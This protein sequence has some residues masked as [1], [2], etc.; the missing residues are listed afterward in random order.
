[1]FGGYERFAY[2][3]V[4]SQ[5]SRWPR[6]A[7]RTIENMARGAFF[8]PQDGRRQLARLL[9]VAQAPPGERLVALSSIIQKADLPQVFLPDFLLSLI[10]GEEPSRCAA[11]GG[12]SGGAEL[13][14]FTVNYRLPGDYLKK[15]DV[16]SSAHGLEVRV[17]MLSNRI[18]AFAQH[19]PNRLKYSLLKNKLL[20]R[21]LAEKYLPAEVVNK[22][23]QG[24]GIPLDTWLGKKGREDVAAFLS[25]RSSRILEFIRQD[26]V[27]S[28]ANQF[29]GGEWDRSHVSRY[30]VYQRAYA[31]WSLETWLRQWK[32]SL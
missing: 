5:I 25:S 4:A 22:R 23:K 32:P 27:H 19:L 28:V 15:I 30:S 21:R 24:F 26:F 2:A 16:M 14:D 10:D 1:M 17:P 13:I 3:D 12:R 11:A 29:A 31:L 20:L 6:F 9:R 8:L 7:L 18:L